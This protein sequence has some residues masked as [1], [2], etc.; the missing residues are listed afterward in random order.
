M[1][2]DEAS[3]LSEAA[4]CKQTIKIYNDH[5]TP[6]IDESLAIFSYC[7]I[8]TVVREGLDRTGLGLVGTLL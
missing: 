7:F 2:Y 8:E 4:A 5:D 1:F 6:R 3:Y